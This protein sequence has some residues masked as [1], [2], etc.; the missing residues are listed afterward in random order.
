MWNVFNS[1]TLPP[2]CPPQK[3]HGN[4][5]IVSKVFCLCL[6]LP[7]ISSEKEVKGGGEAPSLDI[8]RLS[9]PLYNAHCCDIYGL[10]LYL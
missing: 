10:G 4:V 8:Y 6:S 2:R 5:T 3:D 7:L 1:A 9:L